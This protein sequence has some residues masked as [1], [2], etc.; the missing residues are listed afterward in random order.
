MFPPIGFE[1]LGN[2]SANDVS[3]VIFNAIFIFLRESRGSYPAEVLVGIHRRGYD[4]ES[5]TVGNS[6]LSPTY[7]IFRDELQ[8]KAET[9]GYDPALIVSKSHDIQDRIETSSHI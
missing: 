6:V 9:Y 4:R 5:P 2:L 7:K 8:N 3:E 1:D